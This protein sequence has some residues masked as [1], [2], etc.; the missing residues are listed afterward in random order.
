MY[1]TPLVA[2]AGRPDRLMAISG[3]AEVGTVTEASAYELPC[4]LETDTKLVSV[5]GTGF[6]TLTVTVIVG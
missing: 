1:A 2:V 3:A 4:E 5:D 6:A